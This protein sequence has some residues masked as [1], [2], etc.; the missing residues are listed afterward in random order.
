MLLIPANIGGTVEWYAPQRPDA[1]PTVEVRQGYNPAVETNAGSVL[2]AAGAA[3][4]RDLVSTTL[5]AGAAADAISLEVT[6]ADD[7]VAGRWYLVGETGGQMEMVRCLRISGTTVY[8]SAPLAYAHANGG[9]FVGTRL[10]YAI[11]GSAVPTSAEHSLAI[12]SWAV[13]GVTQGQGVVDFTVTRW[14]IY[15]LTTPAHMLAVA[16]SALRARIAS[17]Q[18]MQDAIDRAWDETLETLHAQGVRV[19]TIVGADKLIRPVVYR[20]LCL[21]AETYGRDFREERREL[22]ERFAETLAIYKGN[23][24]LDGDEDGILERHERRSGRGGELWRS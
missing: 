8:L 4:T 2:V 1:A 24:A 23:A 17:D 16:S 13:G 3:A 21:L 12:F 5:A 10:S 20:A 22:H 7:I 11:A 15:N 19:S 6:I 9:A 14:P 18:S